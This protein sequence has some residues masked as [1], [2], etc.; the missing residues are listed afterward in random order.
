MRKSSISYP[1]RR[2]RSL[3]VT[4]KETKDGENIDS[5]DPYMRKFIREMNA[6]TVSL[7]LLAVLEQSDR[8]L[9]GYEIARMLETLSTELAQVKQGTLYPVL[10]SME[11]SGLLESH[12]EPSVSSPPRRYYSVTETGRDGMEQWKTVWGEIRDFVDAVLEGKNLD[13]V[14]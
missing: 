4:D 8:P 7:V 9:Y 6:G 2:G 11:R 10:R 12:V 5:I 3:K 13:Q 1:H 14:D